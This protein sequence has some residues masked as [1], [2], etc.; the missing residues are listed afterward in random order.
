MGTRMGQTW[1]E[2][3]ADRALGDGVASGE[4]SQCPQDQTTGGDG[5]GSGV[6]PEGR[7]QDSQGTLSAHVAHRCTPTPAQALWASLPPKIPREAEFTQ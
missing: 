2:G 4:G 7:G 3:L 1:G 6:Q 5:T